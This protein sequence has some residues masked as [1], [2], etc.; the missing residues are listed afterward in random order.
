MS[1]TAGRDSRFLLSPRRC[2][3]WATPLILIGF[4]FSGGGVVLRKKLDEDGE[5]LLRG[6]GSFQME[7]DHWATFWE[8]WPTNLSLLAALFLILLGTVRFFGDRLLSS[9]SDAVESS[10]TRPNKSE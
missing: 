9:R 6:D 2:F 5:P 7:A 3:L 8:H 1:R 10:R 4:G